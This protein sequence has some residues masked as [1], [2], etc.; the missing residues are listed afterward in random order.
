[1]K[2]R[3]LYQNWYRTPL[4]SSQPARIPPRP[5]TIRFEPGTRRDR[6][7]GEGDGL[8]C[9]CGDHIRWKRVIATPRT[10]PALVPVTHLCDNN[11]VSFLITDSARIFRGGGGG[12]VG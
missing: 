6:L 2:A 5:E 9:A 8:G 4:S 11:N 7:P 3:S 12:E 1:M 10:G